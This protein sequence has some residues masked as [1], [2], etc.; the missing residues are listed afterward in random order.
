MARIL[1]SRI[2]VKLS[3]LLYL[4]HAC[5]AKVHIIKCNLQWNWP[6]F[7]FYNTNIV[8]LYAFYPGSE[9]FAVWSSCTQEKK[10]H[11][12]WAEDMVVNQTL[13]GK[14]S[15][16]QQMGM[17]SRTGLKMN[18]YQTSETARSMDVDP[19][20]MLEYAKALAAGTEGYV[21]KLSDAD[22]ER[23]LSFGPSLGDQTV[24]WALINLVAAHYNNIA[25]EISALKGV[26][27]LKGYPF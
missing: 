24:G 9:L 5:N 17:E 4:S 15:L 18:A 3:F 25:G 16:W 23:K 26:Q 27:G 6:H 21:A 20:A 14:A 19:V 7:V 22:L 1:V 2:F 10:S 13:Q 8:V 11:V 12:L